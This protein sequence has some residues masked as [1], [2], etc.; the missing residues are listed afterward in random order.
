M[1]SWLAAGLLWAAVRAEGVDLAG[2]LAWSIPAGEV[3]RVEVGGEVVWPSIPYVTNGLIAYWDGVWNAGL[4]IHDAEATVWKNL[5][6]TNDWKLNGQSFDA[7]SCVFDAG[8]SNI[9]QDWGLS[10]SVLSIAVC[11]YAALPTNTGCFVFG[12]GCLGNTAKQKCFALLQPTNGNPRGFQFASGRATMYESY[13]FTAWSVACNYNTDGGI[14]NVFYNGDVKQTNPGTTWWNLTAERNAS[15]VHNIHK[16]IGRIYCIRLYN[17]NLSADEI[18]HN[19]AI[20]AVR[21]GFGD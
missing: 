10:P 9:M 15:L 8:C 20:D 2:V 11:G 14:L 18:A 13:S 5:C 19:A 16:M 17:R 12:L 21:F 4:G 7:D 6:G 3:A 1:R